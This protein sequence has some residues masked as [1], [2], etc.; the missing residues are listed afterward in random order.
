[1]ASVPM[2]IVLVAALVVPLAVI[3][4][5]FGFDRWPSSPGARVSERQVRLAPPKIDVVAVRPRRAVPERH[6]VLVST[7]ARPAPAVVALAPAPRRMTIVHVQSPSPKPDH[8]PRPSHQPQAQPAP[9]PQPA[10]AQQPAPEPSKSNAGLLAGRDAPVAR[11]APQQ[12]APAPAPQPAPQPVQE[13]AP[14]PVARVAAPEP[15]HGRGEGRG[16]QGDDD[17]Q[18]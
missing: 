15:C 9:Q 7:A 12:E 11:E 2:G 10:P 4:G 5:T 17:S 3:P 1:M 6:P 16:Q 8:Q 18:Q 13:A 14:Q